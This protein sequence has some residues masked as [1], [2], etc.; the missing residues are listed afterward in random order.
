[1]QINPNSLT[2]NFC[3]SKMTIR[4]C[5][6]LRNPVSL[7]V[8]HFGREENVSVHIVT[9]P[10]I[11]WIQRLVISWR[12]VVK[13][14]TVSTWALALKKRFKFSGRCAYIGNC[15]ICHNFSCNINS[16]CDFLLCQTGINQRHISME[17]KWKMARRLWFAFSCFL[18]IFWWE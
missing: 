4:L 6:F 18:I 8:L 12:L 1:M 5:C 3:R 13:V 7:K 14:R 10:D 9:S 15:I 17:G 2:T 16:P 11:P